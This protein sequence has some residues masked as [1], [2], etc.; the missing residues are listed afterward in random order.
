MTHAEVLPP[1]GEMT[2]ALAVVE[3]VE[4][5]A[6]VQIF[7]PGF[8]DPLL[9][10]IKAFAREEAKKLDI[11]RDKDRKAIASLA[12]KLAKVK[13]GIDDKRKELVSGE[14]RRLAKIDAEGSRIWDEL[15]ALQKEVRQ[16]LT[17]WENAEKERIAQHE[18]A[19][20]E[21]EASGPHALQNWQTLP[22]EAMR[23][24]IREIERESS[25]TD[26]QEFKNRAEFAALSAIRQ[27]E[28][29]ITKREKHDA[30]QAELARL[31]AEAVARE[32][33]EREERIASEAKEQAER[34]AR[35]REEKAQREAL[36][37]EEA[38]REAKEKAIRDKQAAE[39]A[40]AKAEA[41]R[42]AAIEKA[43]RDAEEARIAADRKAKE[44]A[45]AA[46]QRERERVA[47]AAKAEAEA[48]AKR[49]ADKAHRTKVNREAMQVFIS[50][51]F[52]EESAKSII[53]LIAQG[54]VPHV[55]IEY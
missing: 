50:N 43:E 15:A 35:E 4:E 19:I 37:R 32:Q 40:A 24:R 11:S 54:K 55:R 28:E 41:D 36:A 30:E 22:L 33:Q 5:T 48:Q 31:R 46:V 14:K 1:E 44:E 17:D 10:K 29:A 16:P 9:D 18:A 6:A 51:G 7:T 39:A 26:W 27:T 12:H 49:E 20:A 34:E 45:E 2:T 8:I 38:E 3:R 23:D 53:T 21:I 13:T 25:S 47:A 42:L 52:D